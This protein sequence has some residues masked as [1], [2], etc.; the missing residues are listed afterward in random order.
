MISYHRNK[1]FQ[2][3]GNLVILKY[4]TCIFNTINYD[5][6][7]NYKRIVVYVMSYTAK[8]MHFT[9]KKIIFII[10]DKIDIKIFNHKKY[11]KN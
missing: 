6:N 1:I 2:L 5:T 3:E 8:T 11:K 4:T 9:L 7:Y 10:I